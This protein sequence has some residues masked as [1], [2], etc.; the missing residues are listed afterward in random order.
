[1]ATI[2]ALK[3][4]IGIIVKPH[5]DVLTFNKWVEQGLPH[6]EGEHA[7]KLQNL[8]LFCKSQCRPLTKKEAAGFAEQAKA[9][10]ARQS[11]ATVTP[12]HQ[13]SA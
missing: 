7:V 11:K 13:P 2:K 9:K 3:K 4:K 1:M 8:R 10:A 5:V 12:L 6:K